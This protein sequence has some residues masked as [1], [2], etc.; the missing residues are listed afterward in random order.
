M[1][2]VVNLLQAAELDRAMKRKAR[3]GTLTTSKDSVSVAVCAA[4]FIFCLLLKLV[5]QHYRL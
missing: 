5:L 4:A 2:V 3:F 1:V